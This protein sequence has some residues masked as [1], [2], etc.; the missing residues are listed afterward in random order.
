NCPACKVA[1]SLVL[2]RAGQGLTLE[3]AV[4]PPRPDRLPGDLGQ[5]F[6]VVAKLGA[7]GQGEV[8]RVRPR[9]ATRDY[10]LKWTRVEAART[11]VDRGPREAN[12]ATLPPHPNVLAP[13][14][15][16]WFEN[17]QYMVLDLVEGETLAAALEREGPLAPERASDLAQQ[18]LR[19][20]AH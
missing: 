16:G 14:Q 18:I 10:A 2:R 1:V 17:L 7:G 5:R 4:A 15:A 11:G 13:I 9:G 20:L 6:E 3:A 12:Y 19:A 8:L